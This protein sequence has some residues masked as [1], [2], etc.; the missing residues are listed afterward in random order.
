VPPT[1]SRTKYRGDIDPN[2]ELIAL[3]VA[4]A[5]S[6][7]VGGLA[8][9]GSL[10]QSA[11]N[12]GAGARSELSPLVAAVLIVI[13]VLLLTPLFKNLPEAVLAALIIHAVSQ[14]WKV[15]EFRRYY[16]ERQA[17]FWP[18]LA[19]LIGVITI[20]VLPGLVIG[21]TS[22]LLLVIW[23]A[24]RPHLS[25]LGRVPETPGAYG[26]VHR[27][28]EYESIP[29]LLVLRLET[30][31]FYANATPVRDGIKQLVAATN[32]SPKTVILDVGANERLDI[33]SAEMLGQLL[34]TLRSVGVDFAIADARQPVIQ[35]AHR[36]GLLDQL[37]EDRIFHT[38]NEAVQEA[39]L[40]NQPTPHRRH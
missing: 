11:V 10:S 31:L 17:E 25:V 9:G 6:G 20:D 32:P 2:Q 27:H 28:P 4:N 26:D 21:V 33:T 36:S 12:D 5:G 22:M 15:A 39:Q 23:H 19:T 3:G 1:T 24:T 18:G 37:G 30:P 29:E 8:G 40:D 16:R 14:L 38:I 13:T 34:E 35:M 7:L